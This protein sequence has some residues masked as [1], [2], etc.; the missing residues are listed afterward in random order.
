MD[1]AGIPTKW[2]I[3]SRFKIQLSVSGLLRRK[4]GNA[5][6]NLQISADVAFLMGTFKAFD[7]YFRFYV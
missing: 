7:S 3:L 5:V 6:E 4:V 2:I 1:E